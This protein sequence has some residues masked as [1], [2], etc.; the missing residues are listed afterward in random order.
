MINNSALYGLPL[1]NYSWLTF[2]IL[3]QKNVY[4]KTHFSKST[5]IFTISFQ[6]AQILCSDPLLNKWINSIKKWLD[7]K[8]L[9]LKNLILY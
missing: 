6:R 4:K 1:S 7:Y 2:A 3:G 8:V 9:A 5:Y